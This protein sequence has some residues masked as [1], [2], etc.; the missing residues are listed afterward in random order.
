MEGAVFGVVL[1]GFLPEL[2]SKFALSATKGFKAAIGEL[3][4]LFFGDDLGEGGF[5][6]GLDGARGRRSLM[7]SRR[8]VRSGGWVRSRRLLRSGS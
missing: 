4:D 5:F 6:G 1:E 3:C 2:F 8:L 7:R